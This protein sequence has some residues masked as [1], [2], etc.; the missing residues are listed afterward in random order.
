MNS[1]KQ[2]KDRFRRF[3]TRP[4][5]WTNHFWR[6]AYIERT[7]LHCHRIIFGALAHP[8]LLFPICAI[9]IYTYIYMYIYIYI[10]AYIYIYLCIYIYVYIYLCIY[11]YICVPKKSRRPMSRHRFL[12][13]FS[14]CPEAETRNQFRSYPAFGA[15]NFLLGGELPTNRKWVSSPQL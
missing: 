14:S 11:I 9:Y 3:L 6:A 4:R 12:V 10:C 1:W 7:W 2:S 8:I 15:G 5:E 13:G